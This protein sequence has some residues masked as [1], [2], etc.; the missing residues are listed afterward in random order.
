MSRVV[1]AVLR[2]LRGQIREVGSRLHIRKM[3]KRNAPLFIEVGAGD[4][5]GV[6]G[7]ITVDIAE[8]CDVYWDLRNGIPFPNGSISKLYS[9]HFFEHLSFREGQA[10]L[11]ECLRVL[12]PVGTFSIC[13]PNA[14]IYVEAYL[15]PTAETRKYFQHMPS[16]NRTTKIDY[17]NYMAY[18]SG[19]HKYM[20]DEENLIH[21]LTHKGF[22]NARLRK[23]DGEI[24]LR[25]RDYESIYAEAEK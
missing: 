23:F 24:D 3:L 21:I 8:S 25:E 15:N 13:V 16:Y 18:M 10:F 5:K 9:S 17:I 2:A 19:H 1:K 20:F 22:R 6:N 7:W 4:K 12:T 14:R 11:D